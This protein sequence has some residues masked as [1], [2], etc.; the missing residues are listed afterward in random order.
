MK[1]IKNPKISILLCTFNGEKYLDDQLKSFEDQNITDKLDL[2][3]SDDGSQDRTLEI[4]RNFKK[5]SKIPTKIIFRKTAHGFS[6][7]FTFITSRKN[8]NS[9]FYAWSDQDDIWINDKLERAIKEL[10]NISPKIP[11][12]FSSRTIITNEHNIKI[13]ESKKFKKPYLFQNALVQSIAGGNTMVFNES[14]RVLFNQATKIRKISSHDWLMYIA[15]T[16]S[17]GIFIFESIPLVRYR[18]HNKNLIGANI[19]LR[20]IFQRIQLLFM[21]NLKNSISINK[22]CISLIE[23][24]LTNENKILYNEFYK[25]RNSNMI[26]RFFRFLNIGIYRQGYAENFLFY[27]ALLFNKI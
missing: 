26:N 13:G 22:S 11:A 24:F 10:N 27:I 14:A 3:I 9:D 23:N 6:S 21:G 7:N 4:L 2:L 16:G 20:N 17:G 1:Y 15:V 8:L 25:F 12:V 19:S 5:T 18:Q